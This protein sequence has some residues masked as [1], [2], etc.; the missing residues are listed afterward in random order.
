MLEKI[1]MDMKKNKFNYSDLSNKELENLKEYYINEKVKNMNELELRK[2]VY[3]N[4]SHQIK[5]P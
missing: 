3:E 5:N 1:F 2:F 4:I